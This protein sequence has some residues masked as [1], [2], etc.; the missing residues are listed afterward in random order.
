[1][2]VSTAVLW[3]AL[4]DVSVVAVKVE[5]LVSKRVDWMATC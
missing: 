2:V 3:A 1:M 4:K 5:K